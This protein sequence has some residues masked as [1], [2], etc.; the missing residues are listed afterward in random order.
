[1]KYAGREF[2]FEYRVDCSEEELKYDGL[3]TYL[4][5]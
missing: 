2:G 3:C 1:M 5:P 4:M